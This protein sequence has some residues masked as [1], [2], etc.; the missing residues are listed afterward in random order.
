M[1]RSRRGPWRWAA[2]LLLVG[3][4]ALPLGLVG[5]GAEVTA[6]AE[7]THFIQLLRD[8][9]LSG[10]YQPLINYLNMP[11][12]ATDDRAINQAMVR[13]CVYNTKKYKNF[14][15]MK[16]TPARL[17]GIEQAVNEAGKYYGLKP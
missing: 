10:N 9:D 5:C 8:S 11:H 13:W 16:L 12:G 14:I 7:E 3:L 1:K 17:Q 6:S 15:A 2:G 4:G